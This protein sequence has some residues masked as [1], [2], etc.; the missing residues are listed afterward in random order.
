[1]LLRKNA[2]YFYC[3][4]EIDIVDKLDG[5]LIEHDSR[6]HKPSDR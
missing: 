3:A 1:M 4:F 2:N 6:L 5:D